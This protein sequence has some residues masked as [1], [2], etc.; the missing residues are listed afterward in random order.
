[1]VTVSVVVQA[2]GDA[3]VDEIAAAVY[4]EMEEHAGGIRGVVAVLPTLTVASSP[5]RRALRVV[6]VP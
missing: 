4:A 5:D 3:D 1:V 6:R 2:D